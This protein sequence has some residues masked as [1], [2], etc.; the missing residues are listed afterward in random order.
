VCAKFGWLQEYQPDDPAVKAL[1]TRDVSSA[2]KEP[3][4]AAVEDCLIIT[5][6]G[7]P[8][9]PTPPCSSCAAR[10]ASMVLCGC[11]ITTMKGAFP[12]TTMPPPVLHTVLLHVAL[13]PTPACACAPHCGLNGAVWMPHQHH[14]GCCCPHTIMGTCAPRRVILMVLCGR[15]EPLLLAPPGI[16]RAAMLGAFI[17]SF[18]WL[19]AGISAGMQNTG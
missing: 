6:K 10:C 1:L 2:M 12:H 18:V 15:V 3:Y 17:T 4:K 8:L 14:E 11:L 5:M 19:L 13:L 9:A 16:C 7:A